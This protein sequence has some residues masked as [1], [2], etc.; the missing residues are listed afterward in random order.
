MS[1]SREPIAVLPRQYTST[2]LDLHPLRATDAPVAVSLA[3]PARP[4]LAAMAGGPAAALHDEHGL[5]RRS[6]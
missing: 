3:V 4:A 1:A 5:I 6:A 2:R